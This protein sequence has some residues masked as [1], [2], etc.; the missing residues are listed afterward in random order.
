MHVVAKTGNISS[1][2]Q[3]QHCIVLQTSNMTCWDVFVS[4]N[5]KNI[6]NNKMQY[7]KFHS[8][9]FNMEKMYIPVLLLVF[10]NLFSANLVFLPLQQTSHLQLGEQHGL[11]G[12]RTPHP[13][14]TY[15]FML[16]FMASLKAL[17]HICPLVAH[18]SK[19]S[20]PWQ[21][22]TLFVPLE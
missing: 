21:R 13:P 17:T 19:E 15:S 20:Q 22:W 2:Q 3:P 10:L 5:E 9:N 8:F 14:W 18:R 6:L 16:S 12:C 11:F 4:Q 7:N 1:V